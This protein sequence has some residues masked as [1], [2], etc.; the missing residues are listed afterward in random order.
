[1]TVHSKLDE[2]TTVAIALP[3]A[4]TP[5]LADSSSNIATLAPLPRMDTQD[6][7]VKKRA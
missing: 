1:M 4:F 5:P 7:Q 6:H 3:I 2:G